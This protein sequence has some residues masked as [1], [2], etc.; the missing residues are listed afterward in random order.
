MP[1]AQQ[2]GVAKFLVPDWMDIVDSGI[3]LSYLPDRLH[4]LAGRYDDPMPGSTI[5][6]SQGLRIW[7]LVSI[8]SSDTGNL[9]GG[10]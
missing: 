8:P 10:S 2:Y 9:M 1:K 4:R 6:P 3:E 5:V 7:P